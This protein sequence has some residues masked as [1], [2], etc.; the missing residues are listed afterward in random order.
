MAL[1]KWDSRS[2]ECSVPFAAAI[3]CYSADCCCC[4]CLFDNT[5]GQ[6]SCQAMNCPGRN[7]C[8]FCL[9]CFCCCCR[10]CCCYRLGNWDAG[11][12][13]FLSVAD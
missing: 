10:L 1:K 11:W 13:R 7:C 12:F 5:I 8:L 3:L 2:L 9:N 4:C 6:V